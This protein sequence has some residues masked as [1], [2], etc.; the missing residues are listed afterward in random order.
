MRASD[1][2]LL[3]LPLPHGVKMSSGAPKAA[4]KDRW[5]VRVE[6]SFMDAAG[7]RLLKR[8]VIAVAITGLLQLLLYMAMQPRGTYVA[9][10]TSA[11]PTWLMM[12]LGCRLTRWG[13]HAP[14]Q[15]PNQ[16]GFRT[17][18]L[19][20]E[21]IEGREEL[22]LVLGPAAGSSTEAIAGR[23][24]RTELAFGTKIDFA[25]AL[26]Y[27]L[28][29]VATVTLLIRLL[30]WDGW[31]RS[32]T[33]ARIP[34][35][36]SRASASNDADADAAAAAAPPTPPEA[37]PPSGTGSS[38]SSGG[39]SAAGVADG[40]DAPDTPTDPVRALALVVQGAWLLTLMGCWPP[41][42]Q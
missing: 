33:L 29:T 42:C 39:G 11:L 31:R 17:A 19:W 32:A 1:A 10:L 15:Y 12:L 36:R 5:V 9:R 40:D 25:Y 2:V 13:P 27:A 35:R 8:P 34:S 14:A 28:H 4:S 24:L 38:S 21:L 16:H 30:R 26:A 37:T 3:V 6:N 41:G 7:A 18:I 22:D 23:A 20:L